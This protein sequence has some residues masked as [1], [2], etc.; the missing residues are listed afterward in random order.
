MN[1]HTFNRI[2]VAMDYSEMDRQL[3]EYLKVLKTASAPKEA[4]QKLYCLHVVPSLEVPAFANDIRLEP[5]PIDVKLKEGLAMEIEEVLN[6]GEFETS[7]EVIEGKPTK[8]LL[9]WVENKE[10]DLTVVGR[11]E[12]SS[13]SGVSA[14]RFLRQS[15]SSVLFVPPKANTNPGKLLVPVDF[16]DHS[17]AALEKTIEFARNLPY[18]PDIEV[19]HVYDVPTDIHFKISRTYEQWAKM[20]R[21]NVESFFP[22]FLRNVR[23]EG[24][25]LKPVLIEN[26]HF[27]TALHV[28]EYAEKTRADLVVI[29]AKG[30]S[31]LSAFFLGSVTEK[32][33]VYNAAIPTLVVR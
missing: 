25:S 20:V 19:L 16:S 12:V 15:P 7:F 3:L 10:I 17:V 5:T 29:G 14:R 11:K 21:E 31:A 4:K 13:G 28:K 8:Q 6:E 18:R 23:A 1:M 32:F 26:T 22:S 33:M 30:H 9:H 27:N 24:L 2:L